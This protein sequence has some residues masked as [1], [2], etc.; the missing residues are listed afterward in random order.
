MVVVLL[1]DPARV[2]ALPPSSKQ[3]RS[4]TLHS[5]HG[6]GRDLSFHHTSLRRVGGFLAM[7]PMH[8]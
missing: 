1:C 5:A 2:T 3:A 4:C 6:D 8:A 7:A